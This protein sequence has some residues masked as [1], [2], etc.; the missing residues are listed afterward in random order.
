M[1]ANFIYSDL[2][3]CGGGERLT[4]V[5]MKSILEM[6]INID[7]TTLEMPNVQK[8]ENAFGRNF[9]LIIKRISKVHVLQHILD[10]KSIERIM[11][12]GYDIM[13]NTH[14]DIDPFYNNSLTKNNA[15]TYCHFPT[16]KYLI[17]SENNDYLGKHIKIARE[18]FSKSSC[19]A[20]NTNESEFKCT[21]KT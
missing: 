9:A 4:L 20:D 10:E 3:P 6:G 1:R 11:K 7:L 8:I 16:A 19:L 13:I 17:D 2:N 5:T 15:I 14:G 18:A 12:N 21:K